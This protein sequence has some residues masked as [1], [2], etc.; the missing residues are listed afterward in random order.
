[1]KKPTAAL[2]ALALLAAT[3]QAHPGHHHETGLPDFPAHI[4]LGL[5]YLA[6]LLIPAAAIALFL[7]SARRKKSEAKSKT[8]RQ[9]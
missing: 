9:P 3:A 1:M 7:R 2:V 6:A 4:L 5:Q 8:R